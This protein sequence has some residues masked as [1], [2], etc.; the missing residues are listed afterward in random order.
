VIPSRIQRT[1]A[2]RPKVELVVIDPSAPYVAAANATSW[3]GLGPR[4]ARLSPSRV[5]RVRLTRM[6]S[7]I[8]T[9][10]RP[11]ARWLVSTTFPLR[12]IVCWV[13]ATDRDGTGSEP[14]VT[15]ET[16]IH[17]CARVLLWEAGSI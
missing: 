15:A 8:R 6:R 3:E 12:M 4:T 16:A 17:R 5:Y 9:K 13:P 7:V 2:L 11:Q 1:D 14:T 10:R